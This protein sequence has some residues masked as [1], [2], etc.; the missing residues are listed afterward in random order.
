MITDKE[1]KER[2]NKKFKKDTGYG[3]TASIGHQDTPDEEDNVFEESVIK[4]TTSA[5]T[6]TTTRLWQTDWNCSRRKT[7]S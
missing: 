3:S 2:Q 7:K 1:Y 5:K 6:T 4:E